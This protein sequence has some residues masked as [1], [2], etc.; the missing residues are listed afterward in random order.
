M[1]EAIRELES[2]KSDHMVV[3]GRGDGGEFSKLYRAYSA[4]DAKE[5]AKRDY[6]GVF[7]RYSYII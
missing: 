7:I 5:R 2:R 1:S 4:E 6:P 3:M